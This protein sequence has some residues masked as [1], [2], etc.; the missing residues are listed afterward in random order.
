MYIKLDFSNWMSKTFYE[1]IHSRPSEI[2]KLET[3]LNDKILVRNHLDPVF[4]AERFPKIYYQGSIGKC[5][6]SK[7]P[8]SYVIKPRC[9]CSGKGIVFI[10]DGKN[11]SNGKP[12]NPDKIRRM[13][14]KSHR[15][16]GSDVLI[17]EMLF[18][19]KGSPINVEYKFF[20]FG[21]IVKTILVVKDI[22]TRKHR[23]LDFSRDW[24]RIK[25]H[26][27]KVAP[28][29]QTIPAPKELP[30]MIQFAEELG[31]FYIQFLKNS[32]GFVRVDLYLTNRGIVFGE[33]T[34][35]PNGGQEFTPKYQRRFGKYWHNALKTM[36]M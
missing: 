20:V 15:G 3:Q 34:G 12:V 17:E 23:R 25:V 6:F 10:R 32:V 36:E 21:G 28:L 14:F 8:K 33:Y 11:L 27:R 29:A 22:N 35:G 26:T 5:D 31:Q 16:M 7:L 13:N 19:Q 24:R 2:L 18:N 9:L 1:Y 30:E 4:P